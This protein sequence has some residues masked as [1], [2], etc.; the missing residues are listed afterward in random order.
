M[1][2]PPRGRDQE[3]RNVYR[4]M[5]PDDACEA[6]RDHAAHRTYRTAEAAERDRAHEGCH[7]EIVGEI[8]KDP[9]L[10]ARFAGRDVLD[11]REE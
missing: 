6:C 11:D 7:C 5:P 9:F 3:D 4:F 8:V 2:I 1:A 10:M